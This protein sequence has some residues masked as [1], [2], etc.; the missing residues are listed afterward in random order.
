VASGV[1][2]T[3]WADQDVLSGRPYFY[4]VRAVDQTNGNEDGNTHEVVGTPTGP[5][6]IGTWTD[7]AGDSGSAKMDPTGPWSV[8]ADAGVTGAAYATGPYGPGTCAALTTPL[9]LLDL[10]PQLEFGSKYDIEHDWDKGELQ[11]STDGG[12][13]W[14]RVPMTYPGNSTNTNDACGL[15]TGPFFTGLQSTF[16]SFSA[17]LSS[18]NGQSIRLRWLFSSDGAVEEDGWWI[19]DVSITDVAVPG[20]CSGA[21]VIFVDDFESGD[22]S[23][24]SSD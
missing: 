13:S 15:G 6:V 9:M 3:S 14:T 18:W 11:V 19:D 4:I 16:A 8:A 24:W 7:D 22:T 5:S 21:E 2:A 10:D 17:N 12:G 23:A 20:S 1:S